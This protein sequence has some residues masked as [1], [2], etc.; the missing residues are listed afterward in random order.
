MR[1]CLCLSAVVRALRP[2]RRVLDGDRVW[3]SYEGISMAEAWYHDWVQLGR[4]Q[5]LPP[6]EYTK[7]GHNIQQ[8]NGNMPKKKVQHRQ[9]T[10]STQHNTTQRANCSS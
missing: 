5:Q 3:L 6:S 2:T 9:P 10:H 1:F 8:Q 7:W 4:P